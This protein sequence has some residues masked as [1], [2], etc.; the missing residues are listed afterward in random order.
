[1]YI[2][3]MHVFMYVC[4]MY[5]CIYVLFVCMY[6]CMYVHV[7][8]CMYV[9][10]NVT[11]Y[12]YVCMHVCKHVCMY[13]CMYVS[14]YVCTHYVYIVLYI[15]FVEWSCSKIKYWLLIASRWT[16]QYRFM[17]HVTMNIKWLKYAVCL[18]S[19]HINVDTGSGCV[20]L[21]SSSVNQQAAGCN[22][23]KC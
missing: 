5:V 9:C 12:L 17:M 21:K 8:V 20:Q 23:P 3:C 1:M 19:A 4:I 18:F 22:K 15:L 11:Y 16:L 6:V 13:V 2:L 14:M 10:M 7:C